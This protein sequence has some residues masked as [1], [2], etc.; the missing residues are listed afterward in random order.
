MIPCVGSRFWLSKFAIS[1]ITLVFVSVCN[2]P[3]RSN[4]R[5][6]F[7][8]PLL[9]LVDYFRHITTQFCRQIC[10]GFNE[11]ISR[12]VWLRRNKY[13]LQ[14]FRNH[15]VCASKQWETTLH[16]NIVSHWLGAYKKWS[17]KLDGGGAPVLH[18]APGYLIQFQ[19]AVR[20]CITVT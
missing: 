6:H 19:W 7:L 17:L 13:H 9:L 14:K 8:P 12:W 11:V 10:T 4:V 1:A 20:A 3:G 16:C 18:L 15:F 2:Q 5:F